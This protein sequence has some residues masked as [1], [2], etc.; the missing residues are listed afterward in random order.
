[1]S[2]NLKKEVAVF[3]G[4]CFWCMESVF[5]EMP[6]VVRVTSGYMGGESENPTYEEVCAGNSG[7]REVVRV[8]FDTSKVGYG[9]LLERFFINI[10]PTDDGGQFA[11]RGDQYKTTIYYLNEKQR[12]AA[13]GYIKEL[14]E[15]GKFSKPIVTEVVEASEFWPAED[16]HQEYARKNPL[17]YK[18]YVIGSGRSVNKGFRK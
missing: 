2:E 1:M 10:D 17:R 6:G 4:G 9:E 13:E 5:V 11:D 7:H 14:D 15:S 8:E 16:Y 3:A 18:M 12:L